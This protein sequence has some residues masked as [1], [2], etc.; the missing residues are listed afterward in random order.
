MSRFEVASWVATVDS[1]H[2]A[3]LMPVYLV[4]RLGI[5]LDPF[6]SIEA[7]EPPPACWTLQWVTPA[8]AD[9][10]SEYQVFSGEGEPRQQVSVD[11]PTKRICL[12]CDDETF[13]PL[14]VARIVSHLLRIENLAAGHQF[15]HAAA[16]ATRAGSVIL[17]GD[18]KSGK[19]TLAMAMMRRFGVGFISNDNVSVK[20]ES[21]HWSCQG[22]PRSLRIRTDMLG[23]LKLNLDKDSATSVA[24]THPLSKGIVLPCNK[25]QVLPP[26]VHVFPFE[27]QAMYDIRIVA[28]QPLCAI[29][30]LDATESMDEPALT[31]L[32]SEEGVTLYRR[33]SF[34][35]IEIPGISHAP[36]LRHLIPNDGVPPANVPAQTVP[37]YLMSNGLNH[38][39]SAC[40]LL[41]RLFIA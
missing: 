40:D 15:M 26:V 39:S 2:L 13:A 7:R 38:T 3:L 35:Q 19:T 21:G 34:P 9:A 29:I 18:K 36:F 24:L 22:W 6:V 12:T 23:V 16:I 27:L 33:H 32:P 31:L 17:A 4:E 5:L 14:L 30:Y 41:T 20:Y 37:S 25:D 10:S 28:R 11:H 1:A 8:L